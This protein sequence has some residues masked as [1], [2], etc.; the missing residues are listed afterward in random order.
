MVLEISLPQG[1]LARPRR[2]N[3]IGAL[4]YEPRLPKMRYFLRFI[5]FN[6]GNSER[7]PLPLL[8]TD[9]LPGTIRLTGKAAERLQWEA[10]RP[11]PL[12]AA[13]AA[14]NEEKCADYY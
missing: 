11:Q 9:I 3:G 7:N 12:G 4:N 13:S 1:K 8:E 5:P 6:P 14:Q 10:A 2:P